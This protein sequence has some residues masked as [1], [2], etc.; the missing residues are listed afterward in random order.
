MQSTQLRVAAWNRPPCQQEACSRLPAEKLSVCVLFLLPLPASWQG[1]GLQQRAVQPW[2]FNLGRRSEP[3]T[4]D[5]RSLTALR[6]AL[7]GAQA[8]AYTV[9]NVES[10][11]IVAHMDPT[12]SVP[13]GQEQQQQAYGEEPSYEPSISVNKR[14]RYSKEHDEASRCVLGRLGAVVRWGKCHSNLLLL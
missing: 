3:H 4:T 11:G 8:E 5:S 9:S 10:A 12:E 6:R 13:T 1:G 14:A 2:K 7:Q